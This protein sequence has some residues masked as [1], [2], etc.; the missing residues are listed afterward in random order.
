[1]QRITGKSARCALAYG[2]RTW[3]KLALVAVAVLAI[4]QNPAARG[5][6]SAQQLVASG[7]TEPVFA[8]HAPGDR[9]RLFIA[10]RNGV[11]RILNLNTGTLET[12]PFLS[13]PSVDSG[14]EGGLLGLAFH[15]S[16]NSNGKFY[17]YSTHD[18]GGVNVGGATSPFS[19]HI[20]QYT[21]SANPNV[22]NT[23]F[24]PVLNFP[25]PQDNHVGGWVGFSPND[26]YLY[27]ASGDGGGGDD[28]D[29]GHT[30]GTGNAQDITSNLFGKMLRIDVDGDAFPAD[31]AKNYANPSSNPFVGLTG[32]D[33]IFAYGLR[34]PFRDSFDRITGDLWIGDVG[35][36]AYEEV[37][38]RAAGNQVAANYGWRLREG[39]VATPSGDVGGN[40]PAGNVNPV[41]AYPRTGALGGI[42]V[43][44][45]YIYRG[46]DPSLQGVYVF[47]DAGQ[48]GDPATV[49]IW[50]FDPANPSGTVANRNSVL[51]KSAGSGTRLASFGE[52][53]LGN[54]YSIYVQSGEVYRIV[55][56]AVTSGDFDADGDVDD[57]DLPKWAAGFGMTSG[58]TFANGDADGDGDA[59]GNDFLSWQ[60]NLGAS[61]HAGAS[62]GVVP[63]PASA[64]ILGICIAALVKAE[65]ARRTKRD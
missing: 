13:I 49:K 11:V 32:D 19:T 12:T 58:A 62:G 59:D 48:F 8:T 61:V 24:T 29:A 25:R 51:P 26:G 40:P 21:V 18:N 64:G 37:D 36:G 43:I 6:L 44:G 20:R 14:G 33:E 27:I 56:N 53:A 3:H 10:Q 38:F 22:A 39:F 57:D 1:M 7:L 2:L 16:F 28:N 35:Q 4:G 23:T 9:T 15:P 65:R 46:P 30:A 31:A 52:D 55:T 50:T 17:T 63:E 47:G 41:Y 45:G 54:L 60:K 5:A 34:N 42:T